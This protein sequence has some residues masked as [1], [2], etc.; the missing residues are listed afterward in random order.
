MV[1]IDNVRVTNLF[2]GKKRYIF[3][4]FNEKQSIRYNGFVLWVKLI[5]IPY[6]IKRKCER[7][8][9]IVSRD[10]YITK[11]RDHSGE[12]W[13]HDK[14]TNRQKNKYRMQQLRLS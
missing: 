6:W 3:L 5:V 13:K 4:Y 7:Y 8:H 14:Q 10:K 9:C 1:L 12:D 11:Q 2:Y